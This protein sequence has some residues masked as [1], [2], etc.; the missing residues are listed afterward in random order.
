M[1][2]TSRFFVGIVETG[3][4]TLRFSQGLREQGYEVTNVVVK[5]SRPL[6]PSEGYTRYIGRS[7]RLAYLGDLAKEF[8]RTSYSHDIF[9]F[10]Y[11]TSFFSDFVSSKYIRPLAYCDLPVLKAMGKKVVFFL[12]GDDVR[13]YRLLLEDLKKAGLHLHARYIE[14][15]MRKFPKEQEYV[16]KQK[17]QLVEKYADYIFSRPNIAQFL[18]KP[19]HLLWLPIDLNTVKY[20]VQQT[21]EPLIVHAPSSRS[22]KGTEYVLNAVETLKKEGYRFRFQ[23]CENMC[24]EGVRALLTESE[25]VI[26]QLLLPGYGLFSIEAMATGNVVLG[27]AVAGYNGTSEDLPIITATPDT[28][29]ENLK[30]VLENPGYRVE[31]AKKGRKIVEQ[32]HEQKKVIRDFLQAI[33]VQ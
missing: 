6:Q 13:S 7:N 28:I 15:E 33:D 4:M 17:A 23:L 10:N 19:Y 8:L 25:I 16:R 24:N 9:I 18:T 2:L 3:D 32:Y 1:T 21:D 31:L 27:S 20:R 5:P 12:S 22:I 11:S 30:A 29:Y 14:H 26:D